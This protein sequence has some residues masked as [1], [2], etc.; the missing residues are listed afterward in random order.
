MLPATELCEAVEAGRADRASPNLYGFVRTAVALVF[1]AAALAKGYQLAVEV[2]DWEAWG[3]AETLAAALVVVETALA[4][5]LLSRRFV[6][7]SHWLAVGCLLCFALWSLYAGLT[8]RATCECF[9]RIGMS[10]WIT[11][12]LDLTAVVLLLLAAQSHQ[13]ERAVDGRRIYAQIGGAFLILGTACVLGWLV[14]GS[15][16]AATAYVAGERVIV[17]P[18]VMRLGTL[19]KGSVRELTVRISNFD[20]EP[21]HLVGANQSCFFRVTDHLPLELASGESR[22]LHL[23][24]QPVPDQAEEFR[25]KL[26]LFT[27]SKSQPWGYLEVRGRVCD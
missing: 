21:I 17:E 27:S 22:A 8:G 2:I 1:L 9:G 14:F 4:A 20:N 25:R 15:I 23:M 3:G 16:P 13:A 6:R 18:N 11:F 7:L 19:P 10:P 24:V 12:G 26:F 5:L